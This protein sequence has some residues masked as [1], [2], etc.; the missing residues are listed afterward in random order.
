M[1]A[2]TTHWIDALPLDDARGVVVQALEMSE[3]DAERAA[4]KL[5]MS[6]IG[7]WRMLRE[8]SLLN[9]PADMRDRRVR[10]LQLAG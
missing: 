5:E 7:F 2:N 10:R 9:I 1:N 8:L 6:R 4:A 3:G